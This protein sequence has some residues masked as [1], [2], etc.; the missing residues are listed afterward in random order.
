MIKKYL[1][2]LAEQGVARRYKA[3][4]PVGFVLNDKQIKYQ[5]CLQKCMK[6]GF[7]TSNVFGGSKQCKK[8]CKS[9]YNEK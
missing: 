3:A 9:K 5:E 6:A 2:F 8:L 4:G 7:H 1:E